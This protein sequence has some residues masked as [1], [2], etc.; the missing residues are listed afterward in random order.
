[1][2]ELLVE[3]IDDLKARDPLKIDKL[4]NRR[5]A[6]SKLEGEHDMIPSGQKIQSGSSSRNLQHPLLLQLVKSCMLHVTK[7]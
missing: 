6:N 1:M 4:V 7:T 3:P 2:S 5:Q